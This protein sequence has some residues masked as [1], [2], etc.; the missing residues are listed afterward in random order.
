MKDSS[1]AQNL[2]SARVLEAGDRKIV[3]IESLRQGITV[4][5][6]WST[7][8]KVGD[9]IHLVVRGEI[10]GAVHRTRIKVENEDHHDFFEPGELTGLWESNVEIHYVHIPDGD[11]SM[12]ASAHYKFESDN[13]RPRVKGIENGTLPWDQLKNGMTI[14]IPVY[15]AMTKGDRIR[16]FV[17]STPAN[18]SVVIESTVKDAGQPVFITVASTKTTKMRDKTNVIYQIIHGDTIENSRPISF[19]CESLLQKTRLKYGSDWPGY[20]APSQ[21]YKYE[22]PA[23]KVPFLANFS[24]TLREGDEVFFLL[25]HPQAVEKV[26]ITSY[27]PDSRT[28]SFELLAPTATLASLKYAAFET[29]VILY[30]SGRVVASATSAAIWPGDNDSQST[31]RQLPPAIISEAGS[32]KEISL[33]TLRK[34]VTIE[35]PWSEKFSLNDILLL[36]LSSRDS[37][38][39]RTIALTEE[40]QEKGVQESITSD[41]LQALW[42]SDVTL[43][44]ILVPSSGNP[45]Q[46]PK[47]HYAFA[48]DIYRPR[49]ENVTNGTLP[50]EYV[51]AGFTIE[52]PAYENMAE[53]DVVQLFLASSQPA[54]SAIMECTVEIADTPVS[55]T[56]PKE[57]T[58]LA[59][60]GS[61]DLIYQIH[62]K[63]RKDLS[64]SM[65]FNCEGLAVSIEPKYT[66]HQSGYLPGHLNEIE[67]P[68]G[69][70][71][72]SV[73]FM[74]PI[75]KDDEVF[76]LLLAPQDRKNAVLFTRVETPTDTLTF[77]VPV[78]TVRTGVSV[79]RA[80]ALLRRKTDV[81]SSPLEQLSKPPQ[82]I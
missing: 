54:A 67:E 22:S 81:I 58:T 70:I 72:F 65:H 78:D 66:S 46:S 38:V 61:I 30:R 9:Q 77:P 26:S 11:P 32:E 6:P 21:M 15:E 68:A 2:P 73:N 7:K 18:S 53:G 3:S 50:I 43:S 80:I 52:I 16:V 34:G 4:A 24:A 44:Y 27:R 47:N 69:K 39:S 55:F 74:T 17:T 42:D 12:S 75:E 49:I 5:I 63:D 40:H 31:S 25:M 35:L 20:F 36:S 13:Y 51:R 59:A 71:P 57:K 60:G 37:A 10:T 48:S 41:E 56:I 19:N 14:E 28:K 29:A 64:N 23:G 33:E 79:R 76:F 82:E 62:R 1:L 45:E 8:F